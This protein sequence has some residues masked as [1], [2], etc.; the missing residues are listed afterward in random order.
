M[1][2]SGELDVWAAASADSAEEDNW[3]IS[4]ADLLTNLLAFFVL[5]FSVSTLQTHRFE[6]MSEAFAGEQKGGVRELEEQVAALVRELS[7]ADEVTT[8]VDADGLAVGFGQK[9]LF[10]SGRA[11]LSSE[12]D[13]LMA[14][15]AE[16][17]LPVTD[18]YSVVVEGHADDVPIN[19]PS[20]PSNWELSAQR[21]VNVV[22][23]LI[24]HGVDASRVSSQAFADTRPERDAAG[25]L[26]DVRAQNRRVVV[27]VR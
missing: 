21:S 4:Y 8:R 7:L 6:A 14:R 2:D 24:A 15:V 22:H 1:S 26:A 19:T 13:R 27:R 10:P 11:E 25:T 3:L 16:L 17:L 12:G 5:L 9:L 20:F 18:R 23:A